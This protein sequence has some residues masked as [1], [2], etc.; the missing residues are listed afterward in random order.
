MKNAFIFDLDGV[1]INN[2]PRWDS[3]K[4]DLFTELFG[5]EIYLQMGSTIGLNMD[6]IYEKAVQ[7]GATTPKKVL[8]DKFYHYATDIYHTTPIT[9]G[10][11]ELGRLLVEKDFAIGIVSASPREWMELVIE[12]LSFKNKIQVIISLEQRKDLGH[13][14]EPDGYLEAIKELHSNPS[15]TMILEDSNAGIQS[16][17]K[18]GAYVLGLKQNLVDGYEQIGADIYVNQVK[19]ILKIVNEFSVR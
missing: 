12:R 8:F 11:E 16:A 1:L 7:F 3:V 6:A 17:K 15:H 9:D 13:K 2:E 14:P 4:K 18:A 5:K 10:I 19:D